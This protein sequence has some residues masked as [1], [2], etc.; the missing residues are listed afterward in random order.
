MIPI[1]DD[2]VNI[3]GFQKIR[4]PMSTENIRGLDLIS[5]SK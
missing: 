3:Y 2:D 4:P 5:F 1:N